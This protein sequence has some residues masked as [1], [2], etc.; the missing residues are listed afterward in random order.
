MEEEN[1]IGAEGERRREKENGEESKYRMKWIGEREVMRG[2]M[3]GRRKQKEIQ[4]GE[5][6]EESKKGQEEKKH[7]G[8]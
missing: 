3:R 4:K 7:V 1:V 2:K 5:G 6:A 8:R